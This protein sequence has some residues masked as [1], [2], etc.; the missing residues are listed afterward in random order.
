MRL[1]DAQKVPSKSSK[2]G[3]S[4][5]SNTWFHGALSW[6]TCVSGQVSQEDMSPSSG[7]WLSL[8]GQH[9]APHQLQGLGGVGWHGGEEPPVCV[10]CGRGWP[11]GGLAQPLI[12]T[13]RQ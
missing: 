1:E 12:H 5:L 10:E 3:P 9:Q 4:H 8:A 6:V 11:A 13:K 7:R 2:D